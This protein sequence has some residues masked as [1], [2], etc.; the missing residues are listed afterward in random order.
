MTYTRQGKVLGVLSMVLALALML[1]PVGGY[2][3][4]TKEAKS[5]MVYSG[6]AIRKPMDELGPLFEQKY[7]VKVIYNYGGSG[8]L[9][10]QMELMK[11]A[12]IYQP[13]AQLYLNIAKK[14]GFI[15]YE[16][17]IAYHVPVIAVPKGNPANITCLKDLARPGIKVA[18][19][20]AKGCAIGKIANKVLKK[21]GIKDAVEK[22]VVTRTA[23]ANVLV[24]DVAMRMVDAAIIWEEL[25]LFAPDKTDI[26]TIPREENIIKIIPIGALTFSQNKEDAKKFVDFASS[27]EG[28]AI[29]EKHGFTSYPNPKYE[30]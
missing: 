12:D 9:L 23:T 29:Y 4:E 30:R 18:L 27:R 10:G 3:Q 22:N 16:K 7:G 6:A 21:N 13:G 24:L 5:I 15:D 19:C 26:I 20:N 1:T 25:A 17:L 28:K 2:S 11:K 8:D 14:K